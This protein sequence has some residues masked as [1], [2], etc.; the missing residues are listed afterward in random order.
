MMKPPSVKQQA[1]REQASEEA[2]RKKRPSVPY[3]PTNQ[4]LERHGHDSYTELPAP[5]KKCTTSKWVESEKT[6]SKLIKPKWTSTAFTKHPTKTNKVSDNQSDSTFTPTTD[7]A[8]QGAGEMKR[9]GTGWPNKQMSV[10]KDS[11]TSRLAPCTPCPPPVEKMRSAERLTPAPAL[12][13]LSPLL[14]PL[15]YPLPTSPFALHHRGQD[16]TQELPPRPPRPVATG[17]IVGKGGIPASEFYGGPRK[18]GSAAALPLRFL[19]PLPPSVTPVGR[20][21]A[22]RGLRSGSVA[23]LSPIRHPLSSALQSPLSP[24]SQASQ[25]ML[26]STALDA[27]KSLA[28]TAPYLQ[29][30]PVHGDTDHNHSFH[31]GSNKESPVSCLTLGQSSARSS[32]SKKIANTSAVLVLANQLEKT[33]SSTM[34]QKP[35]PRPHHVSGPSHRHDPSC[36]YSSLS[37]SDAEKEEQVVRKK[38][39]RE[40]QHLPKMKPRK[41]FK[42]STKAQADSQR[43]EDQCSSEEEKDKRTGFK[44]GRKGTIK[45]TKNNSTSRTTHKTVME[46]SPEGVVGRVVSSTHTLLSREWEAEVDDEDTE[47]E[48][49]EDEDPEVEDPEDEDPED[50]DPED[51]DPE[52][53]DLEDE[54]P[55]PVDVCRQFS[56]K[57]QRKFQSRLKRDME[58]KAMFQQTAVSSL[59][60]HIVSP[61]LRCSS[62]SYADRSADDRVGIRPR[63]TV[64]RRRNDYHPK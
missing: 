26:T 38:A 30:P 6:Q 18:R 46:V 33:P 35:F 39:K 59:R 5:S 28:S 48:D 44:S 57:L 58:E 37:S 21:A 52:D 32:I 47:N 63:G 17:N 12:S 43:I 8:G 40:R 60:V 1:K 34:K 55:E 10:Q 61:T 31:F 27:D 13:P 11:W 41:L 7:R 42:S 49:P 19:P 54:A 36:P 45:T 15:G 9:G 3:K 16:S 24:Y 23:K 64:E 50:E 4:K 25:P 53:E 2:E 62:R 14:S 20:P 56:A 51:E 29:L 22:Q